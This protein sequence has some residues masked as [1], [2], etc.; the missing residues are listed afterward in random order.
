MCFTLQRRTPAYVKMMKNN[1]SGQR[2]A[3]VVRTH[4]CT[5]INLVKFPSAI[6]SVDIGAAQD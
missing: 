4:E 1:S 2:V 5:V 6:K 3:R